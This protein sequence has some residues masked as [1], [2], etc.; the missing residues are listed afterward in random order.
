MKSELITFRRE[1]ERRGTLYDN[2]L[3]AYRDLVAL[4]KKVDQAL[5]HDIKTPYDINILQEV[6]HRGTVI[7]TCFN[8]LQPNT[9]DLNAEEQ[10]QKEALGPLNVSWKEAISH[11]E[12]T[13]ASLSQYAAH[14]RKFKEQNQQA[15]GLIGYS[16]WTETRS[17]DEVSM[18]FI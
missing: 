8:L 13:R 14:A 3:K 16:S 9:L 5:S 7:N 17:P 1:K 6:A 2:A 18:P 4:M 12:N 11:Y 15:G 10:A